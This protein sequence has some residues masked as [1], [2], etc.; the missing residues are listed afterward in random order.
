MIEFFRF[1]DTQPKRVVHYDGEV[2]SIN[3]Q[4]SRRVTQRLVTRIM[5]I[6]LTDVL[7]YPDVA[8]IDHEDFFQTNATYSRLSDKMIFSGYKE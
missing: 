7:G 3:F 8:V 5:K 4:V 2:I 6:F 1:L